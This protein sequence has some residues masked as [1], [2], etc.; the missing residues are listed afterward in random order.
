[1]T[2]RIVQTS[3]LALST[4]LLVAPAMTG[5]AGYAN[6]PQIGTSDVAVNNPNVAPTPEAAF[7]ALKWV[8]RRYPVEGPYTVNMPSGTYRRTGER[9]IE[10]LKDPDARLL[11]PTNQHLPCYH[12]KRVW[13]RGERAT[14]EVL[15]PVLRPPMDKPAGTPDTIYQSFWVKC[16]AGW[17]P[18]RVVHARAWP[19]GS[20]APPNLQGWP[21]EV[22]PPGNRLADPATGIGADQNSVRG[23]RWPQPAAA[24]ETTNPASPPSGL[25]KPEEIPVSE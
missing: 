1:M 14:V 21:D 6:Y 12:I 23:A 3:V 22:P 8:I 20:D 15:R 18:W 16:E 2:T 7:T 19:I 24:P 10:L 17:K 25:V 9:V 4:A 13:V 11:T 5:C